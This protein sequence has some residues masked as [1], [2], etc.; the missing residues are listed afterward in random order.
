[1]RFGGCRVW[2]TASIQGQLYAGKLWG[3]PACSQPARGGRST[4]MDSKAV[5][6]LMAMMAAAMAQH[7]AVV[8]GRLTKAAPMIALLDVS[9]SSC[10]QAGR[11]SVLGRREG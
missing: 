2:C 10:K 7:S 11:Q 3:A 6:Q 8:A 5:E 4:L 1:M 9:S